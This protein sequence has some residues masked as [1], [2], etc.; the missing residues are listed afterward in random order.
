MTVFRT[1][2]SLFTG[3]LFLGTVALG[4]NSTE[5]VQNRYIVEFED[6]HD[7]AAVVANA[8]A[9]NLIPTAHLTISSKIFNGAS[10]QFEEGNEEADAEAT[11]KRL[12]ELP[13]IKAVW[14]V[15]KIH[16]PNDTIEKVGRDIDMA[17]AV[18]QNHKALPDGKF[19]PHVM[20]Q[21]D[22]AHAQGYMGKGI[23]VGVIDTGVDYD[24]PSLGGCFGEGCLVTHGY[25][26]VGDGDPF[27]ELH[28][29][30]KY[31]SY[32]DTD[33]EEPLINF[34]VIS[35]SPDCNGHGTHVS[36]TLAAQEDKNGFRGAAPGVSLGMYRIFDCGGNTADDLILA[37]LARAVEEKNEI[38]SMSIGHAGGWPEDILSVA[39]ERVINEGII[40]TI[41]NGN[42]GSSGPFYQSSPASGNGVLGI[43]SVNNADVARRLVN[44][45]YS[46]GDSDVRI[47][48]GWTKGSPGNWGNVS[49]PLYV[50]D[51]GDRSSANCN[52][53][54]N[55]ARNLTGQIVLIYDSCP[56][57][58]QAAAPATAKGALYGL[59]WNSDS[60]ATAEINLKHRDN[61]ENLI[62][63][64]SVPVEVA[65]TW[66]RLFRD[67]ARDITVH[68]ED[69]EHL[70][71]Y[72]DIVP[73]A[74]GG[75]PSY[76]S[77]W[78]P[79]NSL[80]L[81]PTFAT[82]GHYILS[83]YP[84]DMGEY[85]VLSGTSM[86][87]PLAAG[88]AALL[89]EARPDLKV[90]DITNLLTS[91]AK[92]LP[93]TSNAN[94]VLA[95]V[96]L[97]GGGMA[98]ISAAINA[99]VIPSK[100]ALLLN[101]TD[102]FVGSQSFKLRNTGSEDVTYRLGHLAVSTAYTLATSL[103]WVMTQAEIELVKNAA[104]I[105]FASDEVTVPARSE[106]EI[107]LDFTPPEGLDTKR[108]PVYSGYVTLSGDNGD[109]LGVPY[110]GVAGSMAKVETISHL[111]A[112]SSL[113]NPLSPIPEGFEYI[114]NRNAS[115]N[116]REITLTILWE[117][118]M[119]SKKV[120]VEIHSVNIDNSTGAITLG[121]NHGNI[122]DAPELYLSRTESTYGVTR[123]FRGVLASGEMIEPGNYTAVV[124][125]LKLLGDEENEDDWSTKR[126]VSFGVKF[127]E[128]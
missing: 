87:A 59:Y 28:P 12:V 86:A 76:F 113:S 88:I 100:T 22:K 81:K 38:I 63:T 3:L 7:N 54:F 9:Q 110:L 104:Q 85:A 37:A 24:H 34:G 77:S 53:Q 39:A 112:S 103:Q 91:T 4:L 10:Y 68:I 93:S 61:W 98:Q 69:P 5:Y 80:G 118:L 109:K 26:F 114:F 36:G 84:R 95:P 97:Q 116:S 27:G 21:V 70:E 25:D 120:N 62:A 78:G 23:R 8:R 119:A 117:Q 18:K 126:T 106:A 13:S 14:P 82:P 17:A 48:F 45:S 58:E 19:S 94:S 52:E 51:T 33:L 101:D 66:L 115:S 122:Q 43:G 107:Q 56:F 102:H 50:G 123:R 71:E 65:E 2:R 90:G 30:A 74:E 99:S 92:P 44:A 108:V 64:G 124:S 20:T 83:T 16:L 96:H 60:P 11:I 72:L 29:K 32:L 79:T 75:V 57:P 31:A 35:P 55:Y 73:Y 121:K 67:Q 41:S 1:I 105:K 49:L 6:G 46:V 127:N 111:H 128:E 42:E 47:P 125:A 15:R 89:L 40:L